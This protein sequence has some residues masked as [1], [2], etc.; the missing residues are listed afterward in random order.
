MEPKESR[1]AANDLSAAAGAG[2]AAEAKAVPGSAAQNDAAAS[3]DEDPGTMILPDAAAGPAAGD[4]SAAAPEAAAEAD[5]EKA[6]RRRR[7]SL[8]TLIQI[9]AGAVLV[10]AAAV[11]AKDLYVYL[12]EARANDALA[13]SYVQAESTPAA[14]SASAASGAAAPGYTLLQIDFAGLK[15]T[16]PDTVGWLQVD[17]LKI[18]YPI[19]QGDDNDQYLH[20]APDG[21]YANSGSIFL[22]AGSR[23]DFSDAYSLIY[24]H[25]MKDRSMFGSLREYKSADFYAQ[26]GGGITLYT[27]EHAWRYQ[28]FSVRVVA[29]ND[30]TYTLGYAHDDIFGTFITS[31]KAKSLYDTGVDVTRDDTV[32]ALSTCTGKDGEQRLVAFAKRAE[33]L[34]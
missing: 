31:M 10:A 33:M 30:E 29:D 4:E 9:A 23:A 11:L 25:N 2:P 5:A 22:D 1:P 12:S 19:V 14:A 28:I 26:T 13:Q 15:A 32:L 24:G 8:L 34:Y 21:T 27:P 3:D 16:A 20:H 7:F 6:P 18:S 17:G